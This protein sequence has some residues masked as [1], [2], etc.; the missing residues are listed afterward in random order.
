MNIKV[1]ET[2]KKSFATSYSSARGECNCGKEFHHPDRLQWDFEDS[3]LEYLKESSTELKNPVT[4]LE[5]DN[6]EYVT[7]CSC[8]HEKAERLTD[9]LEDYNVGVA[10]Y[11]NGERARRIYEAEQMQIINI[12]KQGDLPKEENDIPF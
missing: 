3:E 7:E 5:F 4:Y 1:L 6:R 10:K 11:L 12:L 2:F 8:W 9:F